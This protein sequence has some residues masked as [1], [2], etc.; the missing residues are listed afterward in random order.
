M[1]DIKNHSTLTTSLV[2][3]WDMEESSSGAGAV[4]R[5]DLH[6]SNNLTD[7]NTTA[8]ATGK[9][10]NGAD[11][12]AANSEYLSLGDISDFDIVASTTD[13]SFFCWI[14]TSVKT[15][16]PG[17]AS[18]W[19]ASQRNWLFRVDSTTGALQV[20]AGSGGTT[21]VSVTG[22]TAIDD[23]AWH[24]VGFTFTASDDKWRLFVDSSTAEATSA[25]AA[26]AA[27]TA[28]VQIGGNT[29]GS[30]AY[31]TGQ[32]DEAGWWT[33]VLS[34]TEITDLYNSGSGLPYYSPDDIK[35]DT[36]LST[37]LDHY[38]EL[39]DVNDSHG[40]ENL[41]NTGSA[42]FTT[43]KSGDAVSL[44]GSSQG[45]QTTTDF[46]TYN[47]LSAISMSMWLNIDTDQAGFV[48]IA[49]VNDA[50]VETFQFWKNGSGNTYVFRLRTTAS[51]DI[52]IAESVLGTATWHHVVCTWDGTT[53]ELWVDGALQGT[54][55][56]TG[57]LTSSYPAPFSIGH[58]PDNTDGYYDGLIDKVALWQKKLT[59]AEIRAL[60][61]YGTPP[62]YEVA[63]ASTFTP[64][65]IFF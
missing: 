53:M 24:F 65:V 30:A 44:N 12:V 14:K 50:A 41:G 35:N 45:L 54:G 42:T 29:A 34:S 37:S 46:T 20:F 51:T 5:Y 13:V 32:I 56:R 10:G 61:G 38:W 58:R 1:A 4:T 63:V 11:F 27:S 21:G 36:T 31:W 52:T 18:K 7:N 55:S 2:S 43:G 59:V 17:I 62:I 15:G 47:G 57:T 60:Y 22:T 26:P 25:T 33:K 64:K 28:A 40:S 39:D 3:Y 9:I 16:A 23:G 48:F 8:S 6:G 19:G 49:G